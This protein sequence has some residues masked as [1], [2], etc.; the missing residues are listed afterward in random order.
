MTSSNQ[1]LLAWLIGATGRDCGRRFEAPVQI[2][3]WDQQPW[4]KLRPLTEQEAR[5]RESLG[6]YDEYHLDNSGGIQRVVRRYDHLAMTRY[7]YEHCLVACCL[8]REDSKGQIVPWRASQE[9]GIDV[10]YLLGNLPPALAQW[11]REALDEIN[12]RR[13]GDQ[14]LLSTVKKS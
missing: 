12:L 7:D 5:E 1:Q 13:V 10:D 8:P 6:V 2:P 3:G 11:L 4:V 14:Q 9:T